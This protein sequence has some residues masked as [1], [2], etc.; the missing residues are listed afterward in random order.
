ME[1]VYGMFVI[2]V[3][4]DIRL[5]ECIDVCVGDFVIVFDVLYD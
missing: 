5:F 4:C 1:C 3:K 2:G